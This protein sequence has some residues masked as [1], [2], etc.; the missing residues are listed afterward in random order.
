MIVNGV[1]LPDIPAE[2][3]AADPYAI[4]VRMKS[5]S[6]D[7]YVLVSSTVKFATLAGSLV[8]YDSME[9]LIGVLASARVRG[10]AA[11]AT[12]WSAAEELPAGKAVMPLVTANSTEYTL[13]WADHDIYE[14]TAVDMVNGTYTTGDIWFPFSL[15][16]PDVS[17]LTTEEYPYVTV[18]YSRGNGHQLFQAVASKYPSFYGYKE[19]GGVGIGYIITQGD[20][21]VSYTCSYG[22]TVWG[23]VTATDEHK[24][25]TVGCSNTEVGYVRM[26]LIWANHDIYKATS[27]DVLEGT[28]TLG[29]E[30]YYDYVEPEA[31]KP[32]RYS[33]A[34]SILDDIVHAI[35]LQRKNDKKLK[36]EEIAGVIRKMLVLPSGEAESTLSGLRFTT[37]AV[38]GLPTVYQ[39]YATSTITGLSFET[40]ASGEL[41]T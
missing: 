40:S 39:S 26:D 33:I 32:T 25:G 19:T 10:A 27:F 7:Q 20:G 8:G 13:V 30:L 3:L 31:P 38:G 2:V 24:W 28:F 36:P 35:Q 12:E 6:A 34:A 14:A 1:T 22:D 17:G 4:V 29:T 18:T 21:C 9:R 23:E 37:A 16:Y 11:G 5:A 15:E 41:T